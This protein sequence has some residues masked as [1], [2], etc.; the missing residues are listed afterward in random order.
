MKRGTPISGAV[1]ANQNGSQMSYKNKCEMCGNINTS[2]N[3]VGIPSK[4]NKYT[5]NFRCM[6]CGNQQRIVIMGE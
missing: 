2:T 6:K 4:G 5:N 3:S 1:I